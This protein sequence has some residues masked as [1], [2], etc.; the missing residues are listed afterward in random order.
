MTKQ[1]E[2]PIVVKSLQWVFNMTKISTTEANR[3]FS[4]LI[5]AA[6]DGLSTDITVRGKLVARLIPVSEEEAA[7]EDEW[8]KHLEVI[9]KRP[10]M[11]LQLSTRDELNERS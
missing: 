7:Q 9:R 8:Q 2:I 5:S 11:N 3:Q 10:V 6:I 4:K 1:L